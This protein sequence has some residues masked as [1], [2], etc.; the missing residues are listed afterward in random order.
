[1]P[2]G[3]AD[4]GGGTN[5]LYETGRADAAVS[6]IPCNDRQYCMPCPYGLISGHIAPLQ[7][8]CQRG[9]LPKSSGDENYRKG[10]P[11][12][13]RGLPAQRREGASGRP[14]YRVQAVQPRTVRQSIDIRASCAVSTSLRRNLKQKLEF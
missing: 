9:N 12:L 14:L 10:A 1:M 6:T 11:C 13:S 4:G 3:A 8:V 2:A 7:Q 5:S